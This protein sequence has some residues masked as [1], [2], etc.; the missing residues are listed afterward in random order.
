VRSSAWSLYLTIE[1]SIDAN[2]IPSSRR[3]NRV[4]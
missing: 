2:E 1:F 3:L 4:M